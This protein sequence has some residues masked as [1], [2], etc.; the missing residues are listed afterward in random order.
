[1]SS[2]QTTPQVAFGDL[3]NF[4]ATHC[5][6]M[7]LIYFATEPSPSTKAIEINYHWFCC[8]QWHRQQAFS[9]PDVLALPLL[10]H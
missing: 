3:L 1:M 10:Q 7:A 5:F 9:L 2:A 4:Q 8:C 6:P